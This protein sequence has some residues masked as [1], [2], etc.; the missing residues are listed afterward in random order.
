MAEHVFEARKSENLLQSLMLI[1]GMIALM[2]A[3]GWFLAG[4]AG[5]IGLAAA[6]LVAT[7]LGPQVS[8]Q[9]LLRMYRARPLSR[10]EAPALLAVV[11]ELSRRA[12]LS[13]IPAL[14]YIPSRVVNAF[15]LGRCAA[16]VIGVT[17][18][19]LRTLSMRE[20]AGV[21][22]HE[23]SHIGNNDVWVMGLADM[24]SR[25]TTALSWFGQ[26]LLFINLPLLLLGQG[27]V[28]WL[29]VALLIFAPALSTLL[30]LALARTREYEADLEAA[31]IT[32]DPRGLASALAK[33]EVMDG[34]ILR[35]IFFPG[36]REPD[37]SLLRTHPPT[38]ERIRRLLEVEADELAGV[39][40]ELAFTDQAFFAPEHAPPVVIRVPSWHITGLWH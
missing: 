16:A 19:L 15:S 38:E 28:P 21:L 33:L 5:L 25:T 32:G 35:R 31:R 2:C 37:P 9:L 11:T 17:D 14:Y 29:F 4:V 26:L 3:L 20:L 27:T 24:V 22:A 34:S 36:R 8:P 7:F 30:Q 10:G 13:C 18:G 39:P 23:I 6:W 40:E 12:G 1:A